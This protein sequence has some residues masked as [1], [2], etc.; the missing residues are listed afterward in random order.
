M[1][2]VVK[3]YDFSESYQFACSLSIVTTFDYTSVGTPDRHSQSPQ[4]TAS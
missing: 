3:M 4:V 1:G 2:L